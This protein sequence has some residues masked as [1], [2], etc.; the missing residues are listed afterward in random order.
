MI[1]AETRNAAIE[2]ELDEIKTDYKD[3]SKVESRMSKE[4]VEYKD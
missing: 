1:R 4:N 2:K 3:L